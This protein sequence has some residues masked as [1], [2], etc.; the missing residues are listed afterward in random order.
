MDAS[1]RARSA[2]TLAD[3]IFELL[4]DVSFR[5]SPRDDL[6]RRAHRFHYGRIFPRDLR[7]EFALGG[8]D[9]GWRGV[10]PH[11]GCISPRE[12]AW[13]PWPTRYDEMLDFIVNVFVLASSRDYLS[14]RA[15][16]HQS[17]RIFL[18]ARAAILA[19]DV[20]KT[21]PFA[22]ARAAT[23]TDDIDRLPLRLHFARV[24]SR[25]LARRPW[26]TR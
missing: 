26:P 13:R 19:D 20:F 6:G 16:R 23:L 3:V 22:R 14:L 17:G 24:F 15:L 11:C 1:F 9:L 18:R 7:G 2:A 5:A 12:L 4:V 21:H 10:Q 8:G 25:E